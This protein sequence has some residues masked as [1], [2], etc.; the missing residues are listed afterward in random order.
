MILGDGGGV[1]I[2]QAV[3]QHFSN[4]RMGSSAAAVWSKLL[5]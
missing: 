4:P 5:T 2:D 3:I 1:R